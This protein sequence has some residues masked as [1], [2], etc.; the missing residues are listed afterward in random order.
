MGGIQ[1]NKEHLRQINRVIDYIQGH[2]DRPLGVSELAGLAHV[3]PYH[4][5]RIFTREVGESLAKYVLRRRLERAA[6]LLS[7][8][9]DTPLA[10]IAYGCGFNTQSVFSRNFKRHFLVTPTQYRQQKR[11]SKKSQI[12]RK[13]RPVARSYSHYFCPRKTII[14]EDK[15]MD[16]TFEIKKLESFPIAYCRHRGPFDRMQDAFS[17]LM[18]WAAPRGLLAVSGMKLLSV[19]HDD[20]DVT[21]PGLLTADAAM[22]VPEGTPA[23]GEIGRYEVSGGLYAVGRFE[24][25][26][27]DFPAAWRAMFD[28]IREYGCRCAEGHH[29]EVYLNDRETH[30]QRKWFIDICIPV[31]LL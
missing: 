24:V 23:G 2:L 30:P 9:A 1:E 27:E 15:T 17:K 16:C 11:N 18:Q 31:E 8:E 4:F 28:L 26:M 22:T 29:Y 3:S 19:Y 25:A 6:S 21:E 12:V 14:N 7:S 13:N 5:H 20:P 10:D